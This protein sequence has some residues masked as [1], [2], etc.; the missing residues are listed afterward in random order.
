MVSEITRSGSSNGGRGPS[1][2]TNLRSKREMV[3]IERFEREAEK[4]IMSNQTLD[5][6]SGLTP[7]ELKNLTT[8]IANDNG[9]Y[10]YEFLLGT[11][12]ESVESHLVTAIHSSV[13]LAAAVIVAV[14]LAIVA[15]NPRSPMFVMYQL[16][17][18]FM[19]LESTLELAWL[20]GFGASLTE[21]MTAGDIPLSSRQTSVAAGFFSTM[22]IISLLASL[23]VQVYFSCSDL[24]A[25]QQWLAT[26]VALLACFPTYFIWIWRL[27]LV[28][29]EEI[30]LTGQTGLY[31]FTSDSWV[32][33][34]AW[35]SFAASTAFCSLMLCCKLLLVRHARKRLG[36]QTMN[37]LRIV[38]LMAL[39]NSALPA[40]LALVAC[41]LD[42]N[43]L[44][45]QS[46]AAGAVPITAVLLPVGYIWAQ[47]TTDN[48]NTLGGR[49]L[50]SSRSSASESESAQYQTT[51]FVDTPNTEKTF[52]DDTYSV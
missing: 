35:R 46:I 20:F 5:L 28:G 25:H 22:L 44:A 2:G 39:Q 31:G 15:K 36:M 27:A 50:T 21:F 12:D 47:V 3:I 34:G 45:A 42:Q 13:R 10:F 9:T 16:N 11:L 6:F 29:I 49:K 37:P 19:F 40:V 51:V 24:Y 32:F 14:V 7:T 23:V 33:Y 1:G 18:F 17:F 48:A 43:N 26:G 38:I 30:R 8:F 4:E 52:Q 41:G